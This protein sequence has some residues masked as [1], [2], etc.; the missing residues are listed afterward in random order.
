MDFEPP[1]SSIPDKVISY[2]IR[3]GLDVKTLRWSTTRWL[4]NDVN[5]GVC[6]ICPVDI[7]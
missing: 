2:C 3:K 1:E 7:A 4:A 5:G 6:I